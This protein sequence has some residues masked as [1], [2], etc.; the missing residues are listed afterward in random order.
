MPEF[1][2]LIVLSKNFMCS[3]LCVIGHLNGNVF[4]NTI[5]VFVLVFK[6]W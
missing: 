5:Y 2:S 4:E 6:A 1:S 3:F